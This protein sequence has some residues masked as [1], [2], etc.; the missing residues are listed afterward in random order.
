MY[1]Q[2]IMHVP[3]LVNG[4]HQSILLII[5]YKYFKSCSKDFILQN[6]ILRTKSCGTAFIN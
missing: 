2:R 6:L 1:T 4:F 3:L 5:P